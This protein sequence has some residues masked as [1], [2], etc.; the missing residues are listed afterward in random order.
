M[1]QAETE[2]YAL[3]GMMAEAPAEQRVM[4][5]AA[6]AKFKAILEQY[7]EPATIAFALVGM[8]LQMKATG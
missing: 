2:Y 8:E 7:G 5:D 1:N 4:V 3:K 6:I